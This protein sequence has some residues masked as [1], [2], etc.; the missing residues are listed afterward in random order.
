MQILLHRDSRDVTFQHNFAE[1][2]ARQ[3]YYFTSESAARCS[4]YPRYRFVGFTHRYITNVPL[5][6]ARHVAL[7]PMSSAHP[8]TPDL[9]H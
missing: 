9:Q 6:G 8:D 3:K 5:R 4:G 7:T 1:K 2:D